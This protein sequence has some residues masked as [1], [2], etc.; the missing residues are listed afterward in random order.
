MGD[1]EDSFRKSV[2]LLLRQVF[3]GDQEATFWFESV[4]WRNSVRAS[5]AQLDAENVKLKSMQKSDAR[6]AA[7]DASTGLTETRKALRDVRGWLKGA[8]QVSICESHMLYGPQSD[9]FN[10]GAE[11]VD[12]ITDLIPETVKEVKFYGR[13]FTPDIKRMMKI[14]LTDERK[15]AFFEKTHIRDR[16]VMRDQTEARMIATSLDGF[17]GHYFTVLP[18]PK[19]DVE[20]LREHLKKIE[21]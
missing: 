15:I 9:L 4:D 13:W 11:Y 18:L 1:T 14:A 20:K 8:K 12:Y 19:E 3:D 10:S 5:A 2:V 16:Y 21:S 17:G 6:I 7:T